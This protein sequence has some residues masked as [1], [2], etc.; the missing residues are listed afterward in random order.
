MLAVAEQA[1]GEVEQRVRAQDLGGHPG[2]GRQQQRRRPVA[3]AASAPTSPAE[4]RRGR[5]RG[6]GTAAPSPRAR[7]AAARPPNCTTTID[8]QY[9]RPERRDG[10]R[11]VAEAERRARGWARSARATSS[12][13]SATQ[14]TSPCPNFGKERAR[15]TPERAASPSL[16]SGGGAT[17]GRASAEVRR[18][19]APWKTSS[20][21]KEERTNTP[22]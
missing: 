6:R 22:E 19:R 2:H 4:Q 15:S 9:T 5:G 13:A 17:A 16:R 18:R 7:P 3:C 11:H 21:L 14:A 12:G 20:A 1:P 8:V 10:A